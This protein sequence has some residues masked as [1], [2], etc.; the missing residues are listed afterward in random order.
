MVLARLTRTPRRFGEGFRPLLG[1]RAMRLEHQELTGRSIIPLDYARFT[2][3]V[4]QERINA[5]TSDS[6]SVN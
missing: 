1:R 4:V 2:D 5:N 3:F 6:V